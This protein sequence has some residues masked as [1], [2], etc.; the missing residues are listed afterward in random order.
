MGF[1]GIF[2]KD[3]IQKAYK[4]SYQKPAFLGKLSLKY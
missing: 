2:W 3:N 4:A 1:V